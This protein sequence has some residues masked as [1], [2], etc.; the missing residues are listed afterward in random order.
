MAGSGDH[1]RSHAHARL[2]SSANL[3]SIAPARSNLEM[4]II[5]RKFASR[6]ESVFFEF[7]HDGFD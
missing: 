6:T 4:R 7:S 5:D 3:V 2:V 1:D